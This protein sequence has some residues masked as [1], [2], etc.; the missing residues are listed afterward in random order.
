MKGIL[1]WVMLLS[2]STI[3]AQSTSIGDCVNAIQLCSTD[4]F[5]SI[6][7]Y[8][9]GNVTDIV[10]GTACFVTGES[11]ATWFKFRI[12]QPGQL[13]FSIIPT[14]PNDDYDF[15]LFSGDSSGCNNLDDKVVRCNFA[16]G[17]YV[18]GLRTNETDTT[19]GVSGSLWLAPVNVQ[20]GEVY[21]LLVDNYS[22][23]GNTFTL[24]MDSSTCT[25]DCGI[26][27]LEIAS[28]T[29]HRLAGTDSLNL[30]LT[31]EIDV[32]SISN[33][34]SEFRITGPNGQVP[35]A[36]VTPDI[37]YT[38][39]KRTVADLSR[40]FGVTLAAPLDT[41]TSYLF[42]L[43]TGTD[44]DIFSINTTGTEM[45]YDS[46]GFYVLAVEPTDSIPDDTTSI[47]PAA[48]FSDLLEVYPSPAKN[49]LFLKA[50][51]TDG[52]PWNASLYNLSGE[53]VTHD[54]ITTESH[55]VDLSKLPNGTYFL[56]CRSA[57]GSYKQKV[58]V[59]H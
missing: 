6:H 39:G 18:T 17:M 46:I 2:A 7:Q 10:P 12:D 40:S 36:S 9:L 33:D 23:N 34:L 11:N 13:L 48:Q 58:V 21:Y 27:L 41:N 3:S 54:L 31:N 22:T 45:S 59:L 51:Q 37:T 35:I 29:H 30:T 15:M 38:A 50:A 1:F 55:Q 20:S 25:F 19:A 24:V 28:V 5:L 16:G 44:G 53:Q 57:I 56:I 49:V 4:T 32:A 8:G 43:V 52:S 42:E 47:S 14:S 26:I